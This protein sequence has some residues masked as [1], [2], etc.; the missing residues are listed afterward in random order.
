V[1]TLSM[2]YKGLKNLH[3]NLPLTQ[4]LLLAGV[5]GVA[6]GFAGKLLLVRKLVD[7]GEGSKEDEIAAVER[8][9]R[10]LQVVTACYVAFAHGSN[11]AANA[12]GPLA[13]VLTS[14]GNDFLRNF[15][16]PTT[17]LLALGGFGIVLGLATYG[18]KVIYTIGSKITEVTP[19]RGFVMEF[20]TASVV[21][22][23]SKLGLPVSTTHIIIGAV[24]G[25]GFAR[26]MSALNTRMVGQIIWSWVVT[27]PSAG[28]LA[29]LFFY[30]LRTVFL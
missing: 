6:A 13:A 27:L 23:G 1:L 16:D 2:I 9:L 4:A 10:S 8:Q 28:L 21:L 26:G 24:V 17:V 19:S 12:I 30:A 14:A 5:V 15:G 7:V 20:S 22:L 29:A 25:V 3:L 11:D 18:Y